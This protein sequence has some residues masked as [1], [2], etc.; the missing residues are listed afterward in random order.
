MHTFKSYFHG[1]VRNVETME[2]ASMEL[3]LISQ[4]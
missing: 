1:D 4:N 3:D 2:E